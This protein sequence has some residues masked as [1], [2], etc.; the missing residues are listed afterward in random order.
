MAHY[1]M[2]SDHQLGCATCHGDEIY[3][4]LHHKTDIQLQ[5]HGPG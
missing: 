5:P 3:D 1:E 2:V 4:T